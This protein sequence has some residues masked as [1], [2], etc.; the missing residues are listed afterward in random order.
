MVHC[1]VAL[2]VVLV[3]PSESRL[4]DLKFL[5]VVDDLRKKR[6]YE[7]YVCC[8]IRIGVHKSLEY[9]SPVAISLSRL[10]GSAISLLSVILSSLLSRRPDLYRLK[11]A[12]ILDRASF[13]ALVVMD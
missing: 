6:T 11:I 9:D 10:D 7:V 3:S 2:D 4:S 8:R 1:Q 5:P 13:H 12:E